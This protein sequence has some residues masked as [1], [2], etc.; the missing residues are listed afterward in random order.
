[1]GLTSLKE[2]TVQS[3]YQ[4]FKYRKHL[5]SGTSMPPYHSNTGHFC[6][7]FEWQTIWIPRLSMTR[8]LYCS[9]LNTLL[10]CYSDPHCIP[11]W[12]CRA[13][14]HMVY[15][16][17]PETIQSKNKFDNIMQ[18]NNDTTNLVGG[19]GNSLNDLCI[20]STKSRVT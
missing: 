20:E 17:S 9:H 2:N 18:L 12:D 14:T 4:T 13:E 16:H 15:H 3:K 6:P 5:V 1:M 10:V 7:V 8:Q 19:F 11:V